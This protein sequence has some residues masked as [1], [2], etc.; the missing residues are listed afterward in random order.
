MSGFFYV[1]FSFVL[2]FSLLVLRWVFIIFDDYYV[3]I[4]LIKL[5]KDFIDKFFTILGWDVDHHFQKN[6]FQQEVKVEK[7]QRQEGH[8]SQKRADYAFSLAPDFKRTLFFV[9]AKKP[10][11]LLRQ[12]KDDYFQTA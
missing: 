1:E 5:I 6:P 2:S 8:Q 10:S 3:I 12:N 11:R 9:E 7:A 4:C